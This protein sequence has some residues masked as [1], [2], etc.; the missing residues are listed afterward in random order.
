MIKNIKTKET[1]LSEQVE[2]SQ[3]EV[4]RS[5]NEALATTDYEVLKYLE[6][7]FKDYI[8]EELLTYRQSLRDISSSVDFPTVAN[9]KAAADVTLP[10][11]GKS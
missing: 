10:K 1:L 4:R 7:A 2:D 3:T 9:G 6:Q 5:R 8:P 11:R